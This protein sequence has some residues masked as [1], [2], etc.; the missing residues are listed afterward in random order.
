MNPRARRVY[1]ILAAVWL[2]FTVWQVLEHR[3]VK[4]AA[5]TTFV[6]RARDI[7]STLG[8]VV[9]SMRRFGGIVFQ[10]RLQEAIADL[11]KPGEV[12]SVALLN[13]KNEVV[14]LA[15]RPLDPDL[16]STNVASVNWRADSLMLFNPIDLFGTN[17]FEEMA[18]SRAVLIP[19][20]NP[21]GR[22][23]GDGPP[24]SGHRFDLFQFQPDMGGGHPGVPV[25]WRPPGIRTN[26][27]GVAEPDLRDDRGDRRRRPPNF[28]N[29]PFFGRP[30]WL[31]EQQWSEL[32]A[33]QGLHSFAIVMSIDPVRAT[34]RND[35]LVRCVTVLLGAISVV[36][37]GLAWRNLLTSS[38]LQ[39]RLVRASEMNARLREM[40]LAAAGLAHE[41][42]NPLN[43][44][45]GLA[46]MISRE[47]DPG[48]PT[49]AKARSII[50]EVDRLTA[51]L[52]E[53]INY[54]RPR[55]VRWTVVDLSVAL[56]EI[57]GTLQYDIEE[58]K[59]QLELPTRKFL[60]RADEQLFRQ[61]A[62]N[63]LLNAIQAV[64]TGGRITC[65]A[66]AEPSGEV[67]LQIRDNGGGIP[68]EMREEIFKPYVTTNHQGTG[69]GLAVVGQIVSAH[70]WEIQCLD[71]G[72]K[73]ALFEIR[74]MAMAAAPQDHDHKSSDS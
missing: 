33:R 60:I 10:E 25:P 64:D 28:R 57:A 36:G 47:P 29:R 65:L 44:V 3:R 22:P 7:T 32:I 21:P 67:T 53:F 17:N 62:F 6:S 16:L 5:R 4:Q 41:T 71:P 43:I 35:L 1:W 74:R 70:G 46:Q 40:N 37:S 27:A 72:E 52:N 13:A 73:G 30:P 69:L 24:P 12:E 8:V 19:L 18:G 20:G 34:V 56:A 11:I 55:E 9:R 49:A 31:S 14:L 39:V 23:E 26:D 66:R 68:V 51:Q 58:K 42:R 48:G 15:G 61:A 2:A 38:D 63:L 59:I 54:S 50:N 45:R